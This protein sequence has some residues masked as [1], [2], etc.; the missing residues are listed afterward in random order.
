MNPEQGLF[1]RPA[2]SGPAKKD[3]TNAAVRGIL[4]A[5]FDGREHTQMTQNLQTRDYFFFYGFTYFYVGK[6]YL[7]FTEEKKF[8]GLTA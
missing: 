6:A 3:F 8:A 1:L 2:R 7:G 5:V 4:S